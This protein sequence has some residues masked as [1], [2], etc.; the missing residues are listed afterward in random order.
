M[1]FSSFSIVAA[2]LSPSGCS[3]YTYSL[4][5]T[6]PY[7]RA[8]WFQ[9]S[10]QLV[11]NYAQNGGTHPAF[12]FLTAH[13]GSLQIPLYGYLGLRLP[14][15][16]ILHINPSI[17]PQI[18]YLRYRTFYWM[19]WAISAL[20]N[21][22]HTTLTRLPT[23][24]LTHNATF[25][26]HPIPVHVDRPASGGP[27]SAAP[28]PEVHQ[29]PPNGTLVV[30]N[31]RAFHNLTVPGNL[32]QCRAATSPSAFLPGQFPLGA[33]DGALSTKWTPARANTTAA[34]VVDLAA[35]PFQRV[36][37]L[38]FNWGTT[39]PAAASVTFSNSSAPP[40]TVS[41]TD[42]TVRISDIAI[43]D[44]FVAARAGAIAVPVGNS[45]TVDLG[46]GGTGYIV[47]GG[48]GGSGEV[49]T[50]RWATLR[51]QGNLG[52]AAANATGASVAEWVVVGAGG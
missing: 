52:D 13:G 38:Y 48:H 36:A 35:V 16:G 22:T 26:S 46:A 24:Y 41:S 3:A 15:D 17:P 1:T 33:I 51:I 20:S 34:L 18:P 44:P 47:E 10:E 5:A 14:L 7:A 49:W 25:A 42:T 23:P 27:P 43:S 6:Q 30:A 2:T 12:P 19:G 40:P 29:L 32:L 4:A 28:Q 45:T 50:G 9:L 31:A 37:R 11:D 39:P 21:Q 8:P